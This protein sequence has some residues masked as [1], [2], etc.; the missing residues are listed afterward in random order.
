IDDYFKIIDNEECTYDNFLKKFRHVILDSPPYTEDWTGIDGIWYRKY[1][2]LAKKAG[3]QEYPHTQTKYFFEEIIMERNKRTVQRNYIN[4]SIDILDKS[5]EIVVNQLIVD[6]SEAVPSNEKR[7]HEDEMENSSKKSKS[8]IDNKFEVFVSEQK[9]F[10][11]NK[12]HDK[13]E[14]GNCDIIDL[15][16]DEEEENGEIFFDIT[17][18]S[19]MQEKV[20]K[21]I[22]NNTDELKIKLLRWQQLMLKKLDSGTNFPTSQNIHKL[23]AASSVFYFQQ[24]AEHT[25]IDC[26]TPYEIAE[27]KSLVNPHFEHV[28]FS[29]DI[30]LFKFRRDA[31]EELEKYIKECSISQNGYI[32]KTFFRLLEEYVLWNP[33]IDMKKLNEANYIVDYLGPIFNKTIHYF[34]YV[35]THSWISI[36]SKASKL[37]KSLADSRI[38]DYMLKNQKN[39]CS[40]VFLEVTSPKREDEEKKINCDIYRA[41][42]HAKD[43]IDYDIKKFNIQPS[44]GKKLAIF[45]NGYKMVVCVMKLQY[46]GIYLMV[47]VAN[48]IISNSVRELESIMKLHQTLMSIREN[49]IDY[50]DEAGYI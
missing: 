5:R 47:E 15:T 21:A 29:D 39:T 24:N 30:K 4:S 35:N 28:G 41:S 22:E 34:N 23:L 3:K 7:P 8:I 50:L 10:Y 31:L 6:L 49:A 44:S 46:P 1:S 16:I 45:I 33:L 42:I 2:E 25:Y 12:S 26:L 18:L 36:E 37:R 27:I 32:N 38:P 11:V 9:D 17:E 20:Q 40:S 48:C 14:F 19:L 13:K 43:A